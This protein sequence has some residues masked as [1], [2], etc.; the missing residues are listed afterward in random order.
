[1]KHTIK[2]T[3]LFFALGQAER[4]T[5]DATLGAHREYAKATPE[6]QQQLMHDCIVQYIMGYTSCD[7]KAAERILSQ[8][9][10]ERTKYAQDAYYKGYSKFR[11]HI[12]RPE[13]APEPESSARRVKVAA[14][15]AL[16]KSV[17]TEIL[18]SGITKAE[19]DALITELRDSVSF[20]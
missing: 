4:L 19:F 8:T 7:L 9:R 20:E 11:Y 18:N 10:D 15:K 12:I 14:P 5:K 1:M 13:T 16:V 6:Q 3:E 17:L 2:T